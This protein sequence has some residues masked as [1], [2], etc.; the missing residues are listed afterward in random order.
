M[1][2]CPTEGNNLCFFI[3][4]DVIW[5]NKTHSFVNLLLIRFYFK[6]SINMLIGPLLLLTWVLL[7]RDGECRPQCEQGQELR[8]VLFRHRRLRDAV[9]VWDGWDRRVSG[10][11]VS[12]RDVP[13]IPRSHLPDWLLWHMPGTLARQRQICWLLRGTRFV[14]N[15]RASSINVRYSHFMCN[16][17]TIRSK[18]C[19]EY[20][21]SFKGHFESDFI[22]VLCFYSFNN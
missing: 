19:E 3:M 5:A 20:K 21:V 7:H 6:H 17:L 2:I 13:V 4:H 9:R 14:Q 15:E 22:I 1:T 8:Q 12:A 10:Q 16:F 11:P 18:G